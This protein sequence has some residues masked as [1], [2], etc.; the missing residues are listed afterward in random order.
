MNELLAIDLARAALTTAITL[1]TPFLA[2]ALVV[3]LTTSVLQAATSL[4]EQTLSFVP[5]L[6]ALGATAL[7][8]L[9][10]LIQ[11]AV[12]FTT[13]VFVAAEALGMAK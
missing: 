11:T 8:L 6:V 3:G 2:V 13:R 5:K 4:Q 1:A 9:P 7:L 12:A 10:W